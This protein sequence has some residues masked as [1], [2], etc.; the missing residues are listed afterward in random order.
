MRGRPSRTALSQALIACTRPK[1]TVLS[2]SRSV[3][4]SVHSTDTGDSATR[5]TPTRSLGSSRT[6]HVLGLALGRP[7]SPCPWR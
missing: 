7:G 2:P 5:G 3:A 6:P 4:C 1:T